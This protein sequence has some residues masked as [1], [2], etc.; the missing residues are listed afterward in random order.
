MK[1]IFFYSGAVHKSISQKSSHVPFI[2][3]INELLLFIY[4]LGA[5]QVGDYTWNIY[6][7]TTG[8]KMLLDNKTNEAFPIIQ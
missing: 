7:A 4:F 6:E 8:L 2:S 3:G 5:V 1:G